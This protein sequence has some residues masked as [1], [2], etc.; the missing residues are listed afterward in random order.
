MSDAQASQS[1]SVSLVIGS[2]SVK[3]A[4]AIGVVKALAEGGIGIDRVVGCSAGA[5]FASLVALGYSAGD[6]RSA[7][8]RLWTKELT[9]RRNNIGMLAAL[10][11]RLFRFRPEKFGLRDDRLMLARLNEA[12]GD[13]RIEDAPIPLHIVATDFSNGDLVDITRGRLVEAIRA[14]VA[15]PFAF[16]PVRLDGRLLADGFLADPLPVSVAMKHGARVIVAV[17]FESPYQEKIGSAGRFAFQLSTIMSNNLLR[18]R[19]SFHSVSHH[20]EV[21]A[22]IPEFTQRVRLFDTEKVPYIIEEGERAAREQLPYLRELLQADAG[23]HAA[24]GAAV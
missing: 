23:H 9:S 24:A 1:P 14:S 7:T 19:F 22:I 3:C 2:G 15:L 5:I 4:A 17:G 11:P 6:A 12:F 13:K 21:I 18:S 16:A 10:A 20:S 8:T